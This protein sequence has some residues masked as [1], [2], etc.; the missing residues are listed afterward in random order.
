MKIFYSTAIALFL[1]LPP[2]LSA[3]KDGRRD[4]TSRSVRGVVLAAE[5]DEAIPGAT[6][7]L[8]QFHEDG[9]STK[10]GVGA[11][12]DLNG[13]F[14]LISPVSTDLGIRVS[15]LGFYGTTLRIGEMEDSV[16]VRLYAAEPDFE[17]A[18]EITGVRRSRS[19]EDGCC[20]VESIQ[21]EVQQHAPFTPSPVE[22]LGRYSSC[23]FG[24]TVNTVDGLG[25]IALRGLEPTR[26]GML[27]DGAPVY[28][29]P[30]TYYG[31]TLI[32]SHALQTIQIAEGASSGRYGE[33]ALSGIV[34]MQ[35][36]QPTELSEVTGSFN[37]LG[38][39]RGVDQYDLNLGYTGLLGDVGVALFASYNDHDVVTETT[40]DGSGSLARDYQ[41]FSGLAKINLLL[42]SKTEMVAT[43]I[44]GREERIGT[45]VDGEYLLQRDVTTTRFDGILSLSRLIGENGEISMK[46]SLSRLDLQQEVTGQSIIPG[47][48]EQTLLYGEAEWTDFI[49]VHDYEIGIG[50]RRDD[51][52]SEKREDLV[53]EN[54]LLFIY[55]QDVIGIGDDLTLLGSLRLD[56]HSGPG[57]IL[58]PRAALSYALSNDLSMRV[59]AGEGF[60]GEGTFDEE[61]GTLFG[62]LRW[63]ANPEL[64]H[65]IAR[66]INYDITWSWAPSST[67]AASGN[68]NLYYT[69]ISG[70][71]VPHVDSLETGTLYLRNSTEPAR[72]QGLEVQTRASIEG[73]WNA[74]VALS[75]IDYRQRENGEY[76]R[77]PFSPGFNLDGVLS[78]Q[79]D[80][81]G[82]LIE[83]WGS[84]IGEQIV[85]RETEVDQTSPAYTLLNLRV[86]K[87]LGPVSLYLGGQNLLDRRQVDT[88]PL[89]TITPEP[90]HPG[91]LARLGGMDG[92][93]PQEGREFFVGVRLLVG[94]E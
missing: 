20:R 11:A 64:A 16:V 27:L 80:A 56:H 84:L 75:L 24:R 86:E 79:S 62:T 61:Y 58:S 13:R 35:T 46:G 26:V 93:G 32:P 76:E 9:T 15:T 71:M 51:V 49:G 31:L 23:T 69:A 90:S 21:E 33:G 68:L 1:L 42:D 17:P 28:T 29:G 54:D 66:T 37:V 38:D 50:G 14:R 40:P 85:T 70:R 72:L 92:W 65:E 6:V 44:G 82:L 19:V 4:D 41:R 39:Q 48:I 89:V 57:A 34:D 30:G 47:D 52:R 91:D 7:E 73:G 59:M 25:T 94:G 53:Y 8:V 12:A 83:G 87:E 5:T 3:Q 22:S 18:V 36:R 78:W 10:L 88:S 2:I 45:F 67:V 63:S 74:S 43:V 81:I 60:R 77:V 55:A